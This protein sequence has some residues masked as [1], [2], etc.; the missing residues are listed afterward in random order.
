M[1]L[2]NLCTKLKYLIFEIMNRS[3]NRLVILGFCISFFI[4]CKEKTKFLKKTNNKLG[5][6]FATGFQIDQS[7]NFPVIT[8]TNPWPNAKKSFKYAFIP[9]EKLATITYAKDAYDAI[10]LT[11][12]EKLVATST[13]HIPA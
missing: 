11:P 8:V 4:G 7:E 5:V 1:I 9:K 3:A 12:V 13:T 10:V 2:C 6:E